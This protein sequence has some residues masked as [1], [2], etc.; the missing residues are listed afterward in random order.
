M[1]LLARIAK[2]GVT[3]LTRVACFLALM[4]LGVMA[5]SVITPSP[6]AVVLSMTAGHIIGAVAIGTFLLAVLVDSTRKGSEPK[7]RRPPDGEG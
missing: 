5:F 1:S 6:L 3:E 7:A 2:R 4:A